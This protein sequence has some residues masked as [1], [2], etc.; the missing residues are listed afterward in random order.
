[1][2]YLIISS[3]FPPG[4]GG[5]GMHAYC[6][7]KG[8]LHNGVGVTVVCSM[9][10]ATED[11]VNNFLSQLPNGLQVERIKRRGILTYTHRIRTIYTQCRT[12]KYDKIILTGRFSLWMGWL[13]KMIFAK[14][15]Q[16]ICFIHGSEL[17]MGSSMAKWVTKKSLQMADVCYAVSGYTKSLIEQSGIKREIRVLPNGLDKNVWQ[18]MDSVQPFA[19]QGSPK[20]LTVGSITQRKGQ[21]N[22]INALAV[23]K[24]KYPD[25]HYHIVGKGDK[26]VLE[27]LIARLGLE[28]NVTFHGKL[29]DADVK[30]AY[31][32]ADILCMLSEAT[33]KGDVEGF[34]IAVLEANIAGVPAIGSLSSGLE[35]AI[36]DGVTGTLINPYKPQELLDAIGDLLS[37]DKITFAANCKAW[38]MQHD[39]DVLAKKLL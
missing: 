20:L 23:V 24:E 30:R 35:D 14:R 39:W 36:Q 26:K 34:G 15:V 19:W 25:V 18:D 4:P 16:T 28:E 2:Q 9:D 31:R 13:L 37:K 1:M 3:E 11:E 7:A 12:N 27:P 6:M 17:N 5:I 10:Y 21:H 38:A 29:N 8:L 22:V 32:S 33:E